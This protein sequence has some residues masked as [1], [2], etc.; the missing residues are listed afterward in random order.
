MVTRMQALI[1]YNPF[2]GKQ[3][4]ETN[5]DYVIK[6]LKTKYDE[7]DVFRSI[8]IRTITTYVAS[9]GGNY[10]LVIVAGGDGSL[11][12]AING[13]MQLTKRPTLAYIPVGTVNDVGN[14]LKLKKDIKGVMNII[15]ANNSV[16]MDV[17]KIKNQHFIY[18]AGVG[19]FTNVSYEA[20]SKLKK[21]L[22]RMAYFIE[23]AREL[24]A[25]ETMDLT[26]ETKDSTFKGKYYVLLALNSKRIAGFSLHRNIHP[27]LNDGIIDITILTKAK[28]RLSVFYLILFFLFGDRWHSGVETIRTDYVKIKSAT[29]LSY[30]VD[31]EFAFSEKEVE[32]NVIK[33]AIDLIVSKKVKKKYF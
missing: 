13:I 20:P 11:N 8:N 29:P 7:V 25:D 17:C 18:A 31:G 1:C 30:N 10:D 22:G 27:K 19:N 32:I 15:L 3:N 23:A 28:F 16:K 12:E 9:F 5:L 4:F 2:S 6:R 24:K 26:I 33:E 21:H 14:M